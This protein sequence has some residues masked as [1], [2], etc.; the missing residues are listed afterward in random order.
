MLLAYCIVVILENFSDF[1]QLSKCDLLSARCI[2][3][4]DIVFHVIY[5]CSFRCSTVCVLFCYFIQMQAGFFSG[6]EGILIFSIMQ[7]S[8]DYKWK[9]I[10]RSRAFIN[11]SDKSFFFF[12]TASCKTKSYS[13]WE[14]T[15]EVYSTWHWI[16]YLIHVYCEQIM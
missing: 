2:T 8:L 1:H 5:L 16:L 10:D 11:I 14:P 13:V 6:S 15:C 4:S 9:A 12:W 7:P 3:T